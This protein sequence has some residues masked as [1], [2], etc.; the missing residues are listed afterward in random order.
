LLLPRWH[1]TACLLQLPRRHA[2]LS[3][4]CARHHGTL[5]KSSSLNS[6]TNSNHCILH[7]AGATQLRAAR[8]AQ[9]SHDTEELEHCGFR[10]YW[11]CKIR[12]EQ[13]FQGQAGYIAAV[14]QATTHTEQCILKQTPNAYKIVL[15]WIA[16]MRARDREQRQCEA[17]GYNTYG[18]ER[19]GDPS[20]DA[21]K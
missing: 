5:T 16:K 6:S 20:E 4:T 7:T 1:C 11:R 21:V 13:S 8:N 2:L 17:V 19:K 15:C 10:K 18:E 14:M 12:V 9:G 3:S